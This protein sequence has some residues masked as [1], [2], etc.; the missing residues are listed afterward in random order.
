MSAKPSDNEIIRHL[1]NGIQR[2]ITSHARLGQGSYLHV[3]G[4]GW[5]VHVSGLLSPDPVPSTSFIEIQD[6]YD[7]S[8]MFSLSSGDIDNYGH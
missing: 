4:S 7:F 3:T 1:Q 8:F 6:K 5:E 2:R